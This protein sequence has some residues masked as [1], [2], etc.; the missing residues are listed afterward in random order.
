MT[1]D[2]RSLFAWLTTAAMRSGV[3]MSAGQERQRQAVR[4][5]C[6]FELTGFLR[7]QVGHDEPIG[8]RRFRVRDVA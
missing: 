3:K 8:A 4:P 1:P 7:R 6:G 5:A 2:K